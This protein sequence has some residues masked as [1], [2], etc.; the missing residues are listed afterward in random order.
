MTLCVIRIVIG[1]IFISR[2]EAEQSYRPLL[3]NLSSCPCV[4]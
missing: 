1:F 3:K 4:C 2:D